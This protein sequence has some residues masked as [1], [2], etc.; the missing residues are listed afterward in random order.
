MRRTILTIIT[1]IITTA[2]A[3]AMGY[4]EAKEQAWFLTDKMAYELNLTPE[5]YDRA[6]QINLDYLMSIRT[7]S[8]CYGNYWTYRN[9]DFRLILFDW[10]YSLYTTLDYFFRP[11]R[12]M[13]S[14]WYFPIFDHYRRGY[15]YFSRPTVYV[16][17]H[18]QNWHKRRPSD[19]S[20]YHGISF[21]PATGMRDHYKGGNNRPPHRPEYG[22]PAAPDNKRP[23]TARPGKSD[24]SGRVNNSNNRPG[25][26]E[27]GNRPP[28]TA[29]PNAEGR[30]STARPS[31][32]R[33]GN[34]GAG[35]PANTAAGRTPTTATRGSAA[36]QRGTN[37]QFGRR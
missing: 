33:P 3:H 12:W 17:Y 28:S 19:V 5:Q 16:S 11:I 35:R 8:D 30:P 2:A 4:E 27:S 22:R 7:A 18:G 26:A 1:A 9:T 24:P 13:R 10:Q 37:R 6:Y 32:G 36:A 21:R 34:A 20:P 31:A 15:F 29:R 14:S 25:K 23:D